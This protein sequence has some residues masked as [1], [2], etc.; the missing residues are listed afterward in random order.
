MIL[1]TYL[2]SYG[3][4]R[5]RQPL[6]TILTIPPKRV[7]KGLNW[8]VIALGFVVGILGIIERQ[9]AQVVVEWITATEINTV[10][11][12]LYRGETPTDHFVQINDDFIPAG[13]DPLAGGSYSYTDKD[14]RPGRVYYYQLEEIESSGVSSRHGLI[15][16]RA[17]A[18]GGS[19]LILAVTLLGLGV[20]GLL[21]TKEPPDN[22]HEIGT[23]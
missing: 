11:F 12:N 15:E 3:D 22:T 20:L 17:V 10:G 23:L 21:S 8:L 18:G 1:D 2:G 4:K 6:N 9:K 19:E 14:V 13:Q 5:R 16:V 7:L